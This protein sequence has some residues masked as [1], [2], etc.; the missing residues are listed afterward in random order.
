MGSLLSRIGQ[1]EIGIG[2]LAILVWLANMGLPA[3]I[4]VP[5]LDSSWAGALGHALRSRMQFGPEIAFTYGPLG[6]M[7]TGHYDGGLFWVRMLAWEIGFGLL[8]AVMLTSLVLRVPGILERSLA[9]GL[10]AVLP[11]NPLPYELLA[12]LAA[13]LL[14]LDERGSRPLRILALTLVL[15]ALALVKF[16][17]C[18]A[19]GASAAVVAAARWIDGGTRTALWVVGAGLGWFLLLW[20]ACGQSLGSLFPYLL[21]SVQISSGYEEAMSLVGG[22]G[23]LLLGLLVLGLLVLLTLLLLAARRPAPSRVAIALCL[24][25]VVF[26]AFKSGYVRAKYHTPFFF[27]CAAIAGFLLP[28][29]GD[30]APWRRLAATGVRLSLAVLG[31][32]GVCG[33]KYS[34]PI[35]AENLLS[36]AGGQI[37]ENIRALIDL[38]G[39]R[40]ERAEIVEKRKTEHALPRTRERVGL[41]SID[42]VSFEQAY[43][44]LNDLDWRPRPVIQGYCAMTPELLLRNARFLASADA[45]IWVLFRLESIDGRLTTMDDGLL[46]QE[47]ARDWRP[48]LEERELLL[49]RREPRTESADPPVVVLERRIGFGERVELPLGGGKCHVLALDI[50]YTLAGRLAK[51][52]FRA[53]P[54]HLGI[55]TDGGETFEARIVPGMMRT[56][57]IIDP[58]L[59][60]QKHWRDWASGRPVHRTLA[61]T[62]RDP[63]AGWMYGDAIELRLT[64]RNG[65]VPLAG[66]ELAVDVPRGRPGVEREEMPATVPADIEFELGR[67]A[68]E[69][70]G[71]FGLVPE[72]WREGRS[73]GATFSL[74]VEESN[75]ARRVLFHRRL[76]PRQNPGDRDPQVFEVVFTSRSLARLHLITGPGPQGDETDDRAWWRA[77]EVGEAAPR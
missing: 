5:S 9:F 1:R 4:L 8:V 75:G 23:I 25:I 70:R 73:D 64:R 24:A 49:L 39:Y 55:E 41:G 67:G 33:G 63:G 34:S 42:M 61:V 16:P 59:Q 47:L 19:A 12:L 37:S 53:P 20:I 69:V 65:I 2:L 45:P 3:G 58:Y 40:E 51:A 46:L 68:H 7:F 10:I 74:V 54:I 28:I 36:G 57:A 11:I 27:G 18:V 14:L 31:V 50:R 48:V 15:A 60:S 62:V 56:G 22:T 26:V 17:L 77:V 52:L 43:L 76:D 32:V 71:Q 72:S 38:A 30:L 13:A 35:R 66:P 29:A 21:S 6:Y 44:F